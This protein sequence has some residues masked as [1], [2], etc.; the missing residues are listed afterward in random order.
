MESSSADEYDTF[1]AGLSVDAAAHAISRET[2]AE[3]GGDVFGSQL[4]HGEAMNIKAP[5]AFDGK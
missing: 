1:M 2:A 3:I 4:M 5:F